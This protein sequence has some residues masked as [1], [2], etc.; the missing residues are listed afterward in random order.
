MDGLRLDEPAVRRPQRHRAVARQVF[1]ARQRHRAHTGQDE[2]PLVAKRGRAEQMLVL[3]V[4]GK[5]RFI[6]PDGTTGRLAVERHDAVRGRRA[7][8]VLA[9]AQGGR[10]RSWNAPDGRNILCCPAQR[11]GSSMA[12]CVKQGRP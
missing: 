7:A 1:R 6:R 3:F 8:E 5:I 11:S 12:R 9:L 4:A 10:R 2:L